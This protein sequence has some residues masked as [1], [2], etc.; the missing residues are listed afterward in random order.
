[1]VPQALECSNARAPF[2]QHAL[3]QVLRSTSAPPVLVFCNS[4]AG[5]ERVATQLRLAQFH[6]AGL[7][8]M[9]PQWFRLEA[10]R[11]FKAG[12]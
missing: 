10:M 8:A 2:V 4:A 1:M 7:S 3:L 12:A 6:V 9:R 11:Q 5:V